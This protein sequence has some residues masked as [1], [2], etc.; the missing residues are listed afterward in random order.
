M[1]GMVQSEH[2]S[3]VEARAVLAHKRR[4]TAFMYNV[5]W[6]PNF[7]FNDAILRVLLFDILTDAAAAAFPADAAAFA[8]RRKQAQ[9]LVRPSAP[10]LPIER[11]VLPLSGCRGVHKDYHKYDRGR[12]KQTYL[13][14]GV[15]MFA[16]YKVRLFL[17][18]SLRTFCV[19]ISF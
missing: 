11:I 19:Q 17:S 15:T 8:A 14:A 9:P 12:T 18:F 7:Y 5:C 16:R 13:D 4:W 10:A 3:E 1:R 6:R 2:M